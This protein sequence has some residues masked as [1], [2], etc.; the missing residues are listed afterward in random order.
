LRQEFPRFHLHLQYFGPLPGTPGPRAA[1]LNSGFGFR[2]S[3]WS[4]QW[5]NPGFPRRSSITR[6]LFEEL[7][8]DLWERALVP[9]KAVLRD[10]NLT[11][12]D[13]DALEII[14]GAT[15]VPR[16]QAALLEYLV[17][18]A[19]ERLTKMQARAA[20]PVLL[21]FFLPTPFFRCLG[22]PRHPAEHLHMLLGLHCWTS[23]QQVYDSKERPPLPVFLFRTLAGT[24]TS[25][26]MRT[27]PLLMVRACTLQT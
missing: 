1:S 7:C 15:R 22:E 9:L 23:S 10:T 14:G 24:W 6:E 11:A 26:L 20:S 3:S 18:P 21:P 4:A 12:A 5:S 2:T 25:T 8:S 13:L 16:L 17:R 27:R 19:Q